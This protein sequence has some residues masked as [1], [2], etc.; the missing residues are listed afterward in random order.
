MKPGFSDKFLAAL[1]TLT[2]AESESNLL[3]AVSGGGD[4]MALLHALHQRNLNL[5][6]AHVNYK[7][8]GEESDADECLVRKF[9]VENQLLLYT[10]DWPYGKDVS[11]FQEKARD[12]RYT[13]FN[14]LKQSENCSLLLTAHHQ[15]DR[16]EGFVYNMARGAGLSGMD[17]LIEKSDAVFRP[18]FRMSKQEIDEYLTERSVP[19][20]LDKSNLKS[21]YKRNF[22]RLEVLP[23]MEEIHPNA[24]E[25][26][27]RLLDRNQLALSELKHLYEGVVL[28][29]ITPAKFSNSKVKEWDVAL[30]SKS[31]VDVQGFLFH[32]LKQMEVK[33][34]HKDVELLTSHFNQYHEESKVVLLGDC[35][36]EFHRDRLYTYSEANLFTELQ[37]VH[38]IS[39]LSKV[40]PSGK[41]VEIIDGGVS[42]FEKSKLYL[43]ERKIS[44]PVTIRSPKSGDKMKLFGMGGKSK[45]ISDIQTQENFPQWRKI[46]TELCFDAD[47][48]L[49]IFDWSK[50]SQKVAVSKLTE[51]TIII[52]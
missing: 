36:F 28:K 26:T 38:Q 31:I 25:N 5:V 29:C 51:K 35:S 14:E 16:I 17:A 49:I 4:S 45:K 43:D 48:E 40:L 21:T 15:N 20:R 47:D 39:N 32:V 11:S 22:I 46:T 52:S 50:H 37:V 24:L 2:K 27:V 42:Q 23:K 44:F 10:R 6:V 13:F 7:Q 41:S 34:H 33:C 19:F 1:A 12:F 30:I 3:V 8:R 18:L 9:C